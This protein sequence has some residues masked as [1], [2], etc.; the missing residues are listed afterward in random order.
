MPSDIA[1]LLNTSDYAGA[2]FFEGGFQAGI[3]IAIHHN[4]EYPQWQNVQYHSPTELSIYHDGR[5]IRMSSQII[6]GVINSYLILCMS[7][8]SQY[9]AEMFNIPYEQSKRDL[10]AQGISPEKAANMPYIAKETYSLA[11]KM[12]EYS[13]EELREYIQ[14]NCPPT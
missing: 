1:R 8:L 11:T 12:M 4:I 5:W 14:N 3:M 13:I 9:K 6:G 10:I 2:M 7:H